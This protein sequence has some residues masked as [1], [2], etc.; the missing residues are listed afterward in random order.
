MCACVCA[1]MCAYL[2]MYVGC[3]V[4]VFANCKRLCD[5]QVS[6]VVVRSSSIQVQ[7]AFDDLPADVDF[8]FYSGC[9]Q[10][11]KIGNHV[12]YNRMKL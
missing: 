9:L 12:T 6:G 8:H 7:V 2:H 3:I 10:L 4:A 1:Y 11:V 5:D